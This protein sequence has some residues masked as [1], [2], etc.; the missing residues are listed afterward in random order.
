VRGVSASQELELAFAGPSA[1]ADLVRNR[2][3]TPRELVELFL[4]RIER[5]DPQLNAFRMV[6]AEEALAAAEAL[7]SLDL[8]LAGVPVAIKDDLAVAGHART[9]GSRSYGP[10]ETAD[11]EPVKRLREAG[12]IPLGI[13]NVPELMIWPWTA[14]A[15]NGVTRN[16]WNPARATGGSSGGSAAAVAAGMVPAATGSDGGGSIRIPAAC[17]GLVGMKPSRGRVP[18]SSWL[19]LSVS[20]A[21]ARTVKDSA[22]LLGVLARPADSFV[23]AA[24]SEPGRLRIAASRKVP[25]GVLTKLSNDQRGAWERTRDLLAGL[26][27]E[28]QERDPDYGLKM[29]EFAQTW[30]RG[31]YEDSLVVPDRKQLERSTRGMAFA[32][33]VLVPQRRRNALLARREETMARILGLWDQFDVLLTPGLSSTAIAAEGALGK[34]A[35]VAFDRAG[36]FTPWTPIFNLTGQPAV[37]LPAGLGSDGLPL[38]IQLVGRPGAEATLY[39]LAAQLEQARPWAD[40]RPPIS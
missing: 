11:G 39:S 15:A 8:P 36:R 27:H 28:V 12:A 19:A 3:V 23:A 25:A 18:G 22:L 14:T 16:P 34:S 26:G 1:S 29:L 4:E 17:C 30:I 2:E 7:A 37:A 32:G 21:L 33:R 10:P 13:T 6:M 5:L 9:R 20:G 40:R 35:A 38:S 24:D 31:I